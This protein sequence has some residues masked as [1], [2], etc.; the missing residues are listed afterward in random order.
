MY[1]YCRKI[2]IESVYLLIE[3]SLDNAMT[4]IKAIFIMK[5]I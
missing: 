4:K 1:M 5:Y 2:D 3:I